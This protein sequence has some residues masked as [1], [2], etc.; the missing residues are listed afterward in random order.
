MV[1]VR[2]GARRHEQQLVGTL[3]ADQLEPVTDV[4]SHRLGYYAA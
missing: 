4:N 2:V 3:H 1:G